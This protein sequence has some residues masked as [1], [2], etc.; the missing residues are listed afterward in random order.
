MNYDW[1]VQLPKRECRV[2][3]AVF[4]ALE[5]IL[6]VAHYDKNP[7]LMVTVASAW[8]LAGYA[9]QWLM[10]PLMGP[11]E[12]NAR[13]GFVEE[14]LKG[15]RRDKIR[16]E[17]RG[18]ITSLLVLERLGLLVESDVSRARTNAYVVNS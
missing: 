15:R 11:R 10:E 7:D 17:G 18:L 2:S 13:A 4:T 8:S 3:T 6:E 1:V 5:A 9:P 12:Q 14:A 16:N